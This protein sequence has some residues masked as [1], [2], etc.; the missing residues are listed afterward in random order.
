MGTR[1]PK[2]YQPP[3]PGLIIAGHESPYKFDEFSLDHMGKGEGAQ[4][5]SK[6]LYFWENPRVGENYHES[7]RHHPNVKGPEWLDWN[8]AN[9]DLET[10]DYRDAANRSPYSPALIDLLQSYSPSDAGRRLD[11]IVQGRETYQDAFGR[12]FDEPQRQ[13]LTRLFNETRAIPW[14][15]NADP[16]TTPV[17]PQVFAEAS[18]P[19]YSAMYDYLGDRP[20][21]SP[22]LQ[23]RAVMDLFRTN[24]RVPGA[25]TVSEYLRRLEKM[26]ARPLTLRDAIRFDEGKD[27]WVDRVSH[28]FYLNRYELPDRPVDPGP[29]PKT[30]PF[31]YQVNIHADR[32]DLPDLNTPLVAQPP[33][34]REALMDFAE[35]RSPELDPLQRGMLTLNNL[36]SSSWKHEDAP[37]PGLDGFSSGL[38]SRGIKGVRYDDY[39]RGTHAP[40]EGRTQNFVVYDPSILEIAK[41]YPF[42]LG[43]IL[44]GGAAAGSQEKKEDP[45][46][47]RSGL[48]TEF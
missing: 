39:T 42:I 26:V 34:L 19:Y 12:L 3:G 6:G 21:E 8:R 13:E 23:Q 9:A 25:E 28:S 33:Q 15:W 11:A 38:R 5:Y 31:T 14:P 48:M 22:E 7:F 29:E 35:P 44:A 47:L 10:W 1:R 20:I 32:S 36:R 2:V 4:A 43:G 18:R 17:S 27:D 37:Y 46:G 16:Y 30:G 45:F 40:D 41:R 24:P